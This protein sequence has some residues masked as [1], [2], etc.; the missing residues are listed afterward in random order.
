MN[1]TLKAK[2]ARRP[3]LAGALAVLGFA[4]AGGAAYETG[5]FGTHYPKTP[6]D[7]LLDALPDRENA[8]ALGKAALAQNPAFDAKSAAASLRKTMAKNT[9]P[10]VIARD[11][12]RGNMAEVRG[13][14][15]LATL[16]QLSALAAY[17]DSPAATAG[18]NPRSELPR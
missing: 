9:L 10:D 8:I 15:M 7:D 1:E 17:A 13:W 18:I 14:L 12:S 11:I 4:A 16:A 6:Y 2:I 5:L 3:L